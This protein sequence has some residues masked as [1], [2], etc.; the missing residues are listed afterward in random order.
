[1]AAKREKLSLRKKRREWPV[2]MCQGFRIRHMREESKPGAGDGSFMADVCAHGKRDRKCFATLAEAK[3]FCEQK[4]VEAQNHGAQAFTIADRDRADLAEARKRLRDAP[5]LEAVDFFLRHQPQGES[6]TV[7]Q[8]VEE[9]LA[10]PGRRGRKVVTRRPHTVAGAKWR[11]RAFAARFGETLI[12][13]LSSGDI[14]KWLDIN[15]WHGINRKHYLANVT[16]AYNFAIRKGYTSFN[17]TTEIERLE[18][19]DSEPEIMTPAE[20]R[21]LLKIAPMVRS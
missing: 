18:V 13:E 17:P 8:L 19:P 14:T 1:M 5:L 12:H 21:K 9:Y 2:T 15:Q 20:V 4:K 10:A 11:L 3:T 7:T 6:R 16:A